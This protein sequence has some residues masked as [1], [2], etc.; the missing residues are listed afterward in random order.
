MVVDRETRRQ[1]L[2]YF[3]FRPPEIDKEGGKTSGNA[4]S[5]SLE[6]SVRRGNSIHGEER[7]AVGSSG[8]GARFSKSVRSVLS[9]LPTRSNTTPD[10]PP[11]PEPTSPSLG[12]ASPMP[13]RIDVEEAGG[14][15]APESNSAGDC[16]VPRWSERKSLLLLT[17]G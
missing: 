5:S 6:I 14:I 8:R 4:A 15:N 7:D 3:V 9:R 11:L 16:E 12:L 2:H 13:T 10:P 17:C 1:L